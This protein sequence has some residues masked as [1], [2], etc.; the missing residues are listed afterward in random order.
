MSVVLYIQDVA[1]YL[2]KEIPLHCLGEMLL[3]VVR[4][5]LYTLKLIAVYLLKQVLLHK[6]YFIYNIAINGGTIYSSS[7]SISFEE[8][9]TSYSFY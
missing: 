8:S 9:S 1:I 6:Y 2:L 5:E 4:V 3:I 7:S